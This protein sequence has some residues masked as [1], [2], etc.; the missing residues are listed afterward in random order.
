MKARSLIIVIILG[1][2]TIFTNFIFGQNEPPVLSNIETSSLSYTEGRSPLTITSS[3]IVA[4]P[5]DNLQSA[6]VEITS[7]L[8]S[9]EDVLS[10]T[11]V[12][13]I[14]SSWVPETGTLTLSGS[15]S[16]AN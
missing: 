11:P 9:S 4:D 15:D 10:F 13:S 3:I 14:S 8:A 6:T 16:N 5:D 7:G 2:L 1:T 12:G